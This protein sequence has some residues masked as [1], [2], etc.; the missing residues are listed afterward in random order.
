MDEKPAE[1]LAKKPQSYRWPGA[2][3]RDGS[4]SDY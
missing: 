1:E 4:V 2:R 3:L